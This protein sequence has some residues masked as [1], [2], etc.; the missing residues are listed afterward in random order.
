MPRRQTAEA[1]SHIYGEKAYHEKAREALPILVRHAIAGRPIQYGDLAK[2]LGMPNP[3]NLNFPLGSI[4]SSLEA[5]GK[6]LG[7]KIPPIQCLVVNKNDGLPGEGIG[8]FLRDLIKKN[9]DKMSKSEKLNIVKLLHNKIYQFKKWPLILKRLGLE[10]SAS[11][12]S[13][14]FEELG[15]ANIGGGEGVEHKRLKKFIRKNPKFLSIKSSY[16]GETEVGLASGDSL[17]VSFDEKKEWIGVEIKSKI[18]NDHDILRGLFQ[19]V[20]Y[21]AVM[22]AFLGIKGSHRKVTV[23][24]VVGREMPPKL[25][26]IAHMLGVEFFEVTEDGSSFKLL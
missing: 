13:G 16:K 8:W 3:R 23:Y 5:L 17:D 22:K 6:E 2:Q 18:S 7:V 4:G 10:Q 15:N 21:N 19:C 12:Y 9:Y 20:K 26:E 24:L 25:I 14:F 11:D 1:A